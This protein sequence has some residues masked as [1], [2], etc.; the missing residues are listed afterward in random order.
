MDKRLLSI[1]LLFI[2]ITL[3]CGSV[4]FAL[5]ETANTD[6]VGGADIHTF[7]YVFT[8]AHF[9]GYAI[10]AV[11]GAVIAAVSFIVYPIKRK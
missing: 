7:L 9:G 1:F 6:I 8:K 5:L 11:A 2:G 4:G 10:A 3:I